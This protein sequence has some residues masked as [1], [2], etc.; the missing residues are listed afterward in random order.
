MNW[1]FIRFKNFGSRLFRFVT[2]MHAF[3]GWTDRQ[4]DV[5]SKTVRMHSQLHGKNYCSISINLIVISV[6]CAKDVSVSRH[7]FGKIFTKI[8]SVRIT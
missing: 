5:D 2:T 1:S 3:D 4:T 6:R 7:I 8:R